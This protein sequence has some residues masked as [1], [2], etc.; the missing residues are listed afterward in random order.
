MSPG[1]PVP[2]LASAFPEGA[3]ALERAGIFMQLVN[4]GLLAQG[5]RAAYALAH[6]H[7]T[8]ATGAVLG[9]VHGVAAGAARA[10]APMGAAANAGAG[11]AHGAADAAP[12]CCSS[13]RTCCSAR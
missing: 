12:Q 10:V 9:A 3:V 4:G 5:Y 8:P 1:E 13:V 2:V 6:L 7:A 11:S